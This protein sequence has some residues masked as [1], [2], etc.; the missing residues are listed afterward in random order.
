MSEPQQQTRKAMAFARF[1]AAHPRYRGGF[2]ADCFYDEAVE[3][4]GISNCSTYVHLD[5]NDPRWDK[6]AKEQEAEDGE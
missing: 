4:M 6:V 2:L 5:P 1:A 3:A